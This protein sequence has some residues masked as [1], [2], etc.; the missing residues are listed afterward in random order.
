MTEAARAYQRHKALVTLLMMVCLLLILIG[1]HQSGKVVFFSAPEVVVLS[2]GEVTLL[3]ATRAFGQPQSFSL[4]RGGK[5]L[6]SFSGA[7]TALVPEPDGRLTIFLD[8]SCSTYNAR[9]ERVRFTA[10]PS[11]Q[12]VSSILAAARIDSKL[13]VLGATEKGLVLGQ[14]TETGLTFSKQVLPVPVARMRRARLIEHDGKPW[15]VWVEQAKRTNTRQPPRS[16]LRYARIEENR[17][18]PVGKLELDGVLFGLC[19]IP[20]KAGQTLLFI[21]RRVGKTKP[22]EWLAFDGKRLTAPRQILYQLPL[23][24]RGPVLG[25]AVVRFEHQQKTRLYLARIG[26]LEWIETGQLERKDWG[27]TQ[28]ISGLGPTGRSAVA[29]Y[30]GLLCFTSLLLIGSGVTLFRRRPDRIHVAPPFRLTSQQTPAPLWLR[31][32]AYLIDLLLLLPVVWVASDAMF[33]ADPV[34]LLNVA[35]ARQLAFHLLWQAIQVP[36][37]LLCEWSFGTSAGKALFGL[38]IS[39][40]DGQRPDFQ[41]LLM[42]NLSRFIDAAFM[43]G[44]LPMLITPLH[45]RFGDIW[46]DTMVVV[47]VVESEDEDIDW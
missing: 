26:S 31:S 5:K 37:F 35:D 7:P 21:S 9:L 3:T 17:L 22:V 33:G 28:L 11:G 46:A 41:A 8:R 45:Q 24:I 13:H 20:G 23:T 25:L 30:F 42:R 19:A 4:F 14:L 39:R 44:L 15:V 1:L 18:K 36:Y 34:E 29:V 40:H 10:L 27:Q 38:R 2:K 43:V 16:L 32:S 47:D 12:P 6:G